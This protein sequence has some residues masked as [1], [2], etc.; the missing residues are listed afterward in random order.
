VKL[1]LEGSTD[2]TWVALL[3]R[4]LRITMDWT[5]AAGVTLRLEGRLVGLWVAELARSGD[6]QRAGAASLAL[7]LGAV[8]FVDGDGLSLI[9]LLEGRGV[10]VRNSPF[11]AQQLRGAALARRPGQT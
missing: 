5:A 11:V 7:D 6:R 2:G 3:E 9:S 8:A 10:G 1:C 4:M